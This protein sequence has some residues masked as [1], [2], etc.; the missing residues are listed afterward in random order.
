MSSFAQDT[1]E[2]AQKTQAET[3]KETQKE[4]SAKQASRK[5]S[6]PNRKK[7]LLEVFTD[8]EPRRSQLFLQSCA[9]CAS[10]MT[11]SSEFVVIGN[12][13]IADTPLMLGL[14]VRDSNLVC[15]NHWRA[16]KVLYEE[17]LKTVR[18][19]FASACAVELEMAL[20]KKREAQMQGQEEDPK[21][22]IKCDQGTKADNEGTSGNKNEIMPT[23]KN[24]T[25][26]TRE[27]MR[28]EQQKEDA[29]KSKEKK[30]NKR[31]HNTKKQNAQSKNENSIKKEKINTRSS[32]KNKNDQTTTANSQNSK[33]NKSEKEAPEKVEI[34]AETEEALKKQ[35][36]EKGAEPQETQNPTISKDLEE[37]A[38]LQYNRC[39]LTAE[40]IP[41]GCVFTPLS[42][43]TNELPVLTLDHFTDDFIE[44][45]AW[46]RIQQINQSL[47]LS[48]TDYSEN[49]SED[50]TENIK[51]ENY[52]IDE[53]IT[54]YK[55]GDYLRR[56]LPV[57]LEHHCH[58]GCSGNE[59]LSSVP[60]LVH[61]AMISRWKTG[62]EPKT[63]SN[64]PLKSN[65]KDLPYYNVKNIEKIFSKDA[66]DHTVTSKS[67]SKKEKS[68]KENSKKSKETQAEKSKSGKEAKAGKKRQREHDHAENESG[69]RAKHFKALGKEKLDEI[70]KTTK[71]VK[72]DTY[73][74]VFSGT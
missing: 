12:G 35:E 5:E 74:A 29:S 13:R 26:K 61:Q 11:W 71:R 32:S 15:I 34:E 24:S 70:R 23:S 56:R 4:D 45:L 72:S 60:P 54:R 7:K 25:E 64:R 30:E 39:C 6:T 59:P 40:A 58:S 57:Y 55:T 20:N 27:E 51:R 17:S 52:N 28:T 33:A 9:Y 14:P 22:P 38:K 65:D 31:S 67:L 1:K 73:H 66:Q 42:L 10:P 41:S 47:R 62:K 44:F 19:E 49:S 50:Q 8:H 37:F 2:Q 46:Q 63:G 43:I 21:A 68:T 36:S 69:K 48:R 53:I 16:N 3:I 18:D